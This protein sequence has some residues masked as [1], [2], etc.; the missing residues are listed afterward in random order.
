MLPENLTE[1]VMS[2]PKWWNGG[3][4][5]SSYPNFFE[6]QPYYTVTEKSGEIEENVKCLKISAHIL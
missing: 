6:F 5:F 2:F 3:H 1:N 4:L